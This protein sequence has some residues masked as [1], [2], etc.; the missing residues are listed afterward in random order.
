[1]ELEV[2]NG[3]N[4][5]IAD[6]VEAMELEVDDQEESETR[7]DHHP[8]H[9]NLKDSI[10]LHMAARVE[11]YIL[12]PRHFFGFLGTPSE[13]NKDIFWGSGPPKYDILSTLLGPPKKIRKKKHQAG[14]KEIF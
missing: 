4:G 1:M 9:Q 7:H 13:N 12:I 6:P 3:S 5:S 14:Y 11:L 10:A 8:Q 2:S